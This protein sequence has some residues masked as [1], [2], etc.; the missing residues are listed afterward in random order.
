MNLLKS[1]DDSWAVLLS[2]AQLWM[3]SG[4]F[5]C[6]LVHFALK[7]LIYHCFNKE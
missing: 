5:Q 4:G 6:G 7:Q 3:H 2:N 1:N